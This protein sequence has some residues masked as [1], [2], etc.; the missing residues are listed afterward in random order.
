[1]PGKHHSILAM[2]VHAVTW[3]RMLEVRCNNDQMRNLVTT[4]LESGSPG[5]KVWGIEVVGDL[6]TPNN[7][8]GS[9]IL[10][11]SYTSLSLSSTSILSIIYYLS[12]FFLTLSLN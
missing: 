2:M 1:M 9:L 7:S 10:D 12:L 5:E 4:P 3:E 6:H 11:T 8:P